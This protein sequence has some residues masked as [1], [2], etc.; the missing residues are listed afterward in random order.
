VYLYR[1]VD[2]ARH[3]DLF[4]SRNRNAAKSF[5]RNAVKSTRVPTKTTLDADAASHRAVRAMLEDSETPGRV[6]VR[7]SQYL[8]DLVEQDHRRRGTLRRANSAGAIQLS[9]SCGKRHSLLD[10]IGNHSTTRSLTDLTLSLS[11]HQRERVALFSRLWY[12]ASH[13]LRRTWGSLKPPNHYQ[14]R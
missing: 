10:S 3:V 2:K 11:L 12:S 14:Q 5:V 1:A 4:L 13:K 9:R 6:E 7:S 8:N